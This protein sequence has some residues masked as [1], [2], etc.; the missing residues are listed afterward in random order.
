MTEDSPNI[1]SIVP[2]KN[3]RKSLCEVLNE[4]IVFAEEKRKLKNNS[5]KNKQSW[6]RIAISAISAYG[7]LVKDSE[8]E[9]IE[10]RLEKLESENSERLLQRRGEKMSFHK[11]VKKLED[12][13]GRVSKKNP[14]YTESQRQCDKALREW[15]RLETSASME[16][17]ERL[18]ME[19]EAE[20]VENFGEIYPEAF[21]CF[22]PQISLN[23][24]QLTSKHPIDHH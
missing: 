19:L 15:H 21:K 16:E 5:D 4:I 6:S 10:E 3:Q 9:N 2:L 11:R 14:D 24:P 20:P 13:L 18:I 1:T 8:L 17:I 22:K 23:N 7:S 12:R